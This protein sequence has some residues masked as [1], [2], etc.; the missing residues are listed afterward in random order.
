MIDVQKF[1]GEVVDEMKRRFPSSFPE[2]SE[3]NGQI[4]SIIAVVA[5]IAIEKYERE[6]LR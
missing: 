6:N 3:L 2:D 5:A 4:V 1:A